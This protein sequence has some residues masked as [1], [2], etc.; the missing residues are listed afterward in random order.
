MATKKQSSRPR[1]SY[2]EGHLRDPEIEKKMDPDYRE[3]DLWTLIKKAVKVKPP[4]KR[5]AS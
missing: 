4:A 2:E 1:P 5:A 3:S